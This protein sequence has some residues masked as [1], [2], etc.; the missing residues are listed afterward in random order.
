MHGDPDVGGIAML[1]AENINFRGFA[2]S[3]PYFFDADWGNK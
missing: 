3:N 2:R 1:V